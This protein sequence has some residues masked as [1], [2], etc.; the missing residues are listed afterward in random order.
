MY[1]V[2]A[3][4]SAFFSALTSI[5]AKCGI[6]KTDSTLATACRTVVVLFFAWL[7]AFITGSAGDVVSVSASSW[8]FLIL[9]G[10][11]TG[12][13]WLCY[14]RALQLGQVSKVVPVD[15]SSTI[16]TVI[17]S[18]IIFSER[19]SSAG[20]AGLVLMAAGTFMMIEKKE[21]D[22]SKSESSLW[23]AY[24]AGSALFASLTSILAKAGIT[25]VDSNLATAVRT[26]VVLAMAWLMVPVTSSSR[27]SL[28]IGA[29][30]A[31]FIA[32]SGLATGASWLCYY[33]ALQTGPASI[34]A[35]VDRLSIVITVI[36]ARLVYGEKLTRL[37]L[38]GLILVVS[39]MIMMLF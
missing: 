12:A 6:R 26:T 10:L 32:L 37:S 29:R 25:N 35:P 27:P 15:K 16:L 7:M 39:G 17:L 19:L 14:F 30:E 3:F 1:L 36:F 20:L 11:A 2:F 4:G 38:A 5:L 18:F 28:R 33:R 22:R 13:S 21:D 31:V 34:V 24:A 23:L 9:S 8:L